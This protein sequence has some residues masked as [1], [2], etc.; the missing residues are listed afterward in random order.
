[1]NTVNLFID[2]RLVAFVSLLIAGLFAA[3]SEDEAVAPDKNSPPEVVFTVAALA[4]PRNTDGV[5]LSVSATDPDG[6]D[7]SVLWEITRGVLTASQQG[8]P[9]INWKT[10]TTTG[11]ETITVTASDGKG[12]TTTLVETIMVGT[13]KQSGT[14]SSEPWTVTNSPYIIRPSGDQNVRFLISNVVLNVE[15]GS[16]LLLDAEDLEIVLEGTLRTS[17]TLENPVVIRPN[18]RHPESGYWKGITAIPNS[19]VPRIELAYTDLLYATEAAKTTTGGEIVLDGCRIMFA[20]EAA[21]LHQSFASLSVIN[22]I[23]TN[24]VRSGIRIECSSNIHFPPTV[25]VSNDSIAVNGDVSGATPYVDQAAIYIEMADSFAT[26]DIQITNNEISRNAFPAIQLVGASRPDIR[27]NAIFFN[28]L[29]K[30]TIPRFNIRL[31]DGFGGGVSGMIDARQNYWGAPYTNP[32][33]DSLLIQDAI[34][35]STDV[36][37]I[38]VR[39]AIYP[40]LNAKP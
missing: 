6:D 28:E 5:T 17:G 20:A 37:S 16:E 11:R 14:S 21:V 9:S 13:V 18:I 34:R 7:V 4:V 30:Q 12:G 23:L 36:R 26:S 15:A 35:D 2:K 1:M 29:G 3:C 39:V 32:A 24:N 27:D 33:T 8:N 25:V 40:W 31:D 38:S 10:P 19:S 22:S